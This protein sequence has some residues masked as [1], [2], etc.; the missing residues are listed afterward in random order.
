MAA[1]GSQALSNAKKLGFDIVDFVSQNRAD[2]KNHGQMRIRDFSKY[3]N[4]K[5]LDD[6]I[7]LTAADRALD[8]EDHRKE[9]SEEQRQR[10]IEGNI[11]G[12]YAELVFVMDFVRDDYL[13]DWLKSVYV[14]SSK[15][16]TGG[17]AGSDI[18]SEWTY[19]G[20][21][22]EI[23]SCHKYSRTLRFSKKTQYPL[24]LAI[25]YEFIHKE[26]YV[27]FP[28]RMIKRLRFKDKLYCRKIQE[29]NKMLKLEEKLEE[30]RAGT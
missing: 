26:K 29:F 6:W 5:L 28:L 23:K 15:I 25:A 13:V 20:F 8:F 16:N 9:I 30:K 17:N 12:I 7:S 18:K 27:A 14:V 10:N 3:H 4:Y 24:V 2:Y 21:D 19:S 22:I 1:T 11:R